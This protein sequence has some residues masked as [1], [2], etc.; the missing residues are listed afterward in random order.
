MMKVLV[1]LLA[2]EK[3]DVDAVPLK[4]TDQ[5]N[6]ADDSVFSRVQ[7]QKIQEGMNEPVI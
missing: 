1:V 2:A 6:T 4:V 5:S 3:C 7:T